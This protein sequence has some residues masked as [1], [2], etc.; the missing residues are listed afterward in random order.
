MTSYF[1]QRFLQHLDILNV[2]TVFEV[3]ARYGDETLEL[4]KVFQNA[5]I[6]SFECNPITIDLCKSKLSNKENIEFISCG[7]GD[8]NEKLP[9]YSFMDNNDGASSLL[10]RID[11]ETTQK[12]TGIID[13]VKLSDIVSEKKINSIDFLCM[14]V[15]GYEL[16]VLKGAENFIQNIKY[17]IMEEPKPIINTTFLPV[18][19]HSKYLN[20]PTSQEIKEFMLKNNFTEIER[21]QENMI[22]DNVMYKNNNFIITE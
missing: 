2:E 7:L 11:F 13:I 12:Q 15:Q 4:A 9:F 16:N 18:N 8:K 14:D 6:Y 5:K 19:V 3:G 22:E 1:D 20:S 17:I 10:K 21:L